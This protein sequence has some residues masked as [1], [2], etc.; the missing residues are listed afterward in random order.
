[1][2]SLL[3]HVFFLLFGHIF[4]FYIVLTLFFVSQLY[5]LTKYSIML[6]KMYWRRN[7]SSNHGK[8]EVARPM[9]TRQPH[10]IIV[11]DQ[12]VENAIYGNKK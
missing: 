5:C 9:Q 1:M 8:Y 2:G 6:I 7:S 10:S 4:L 11:I 3:G 12:P